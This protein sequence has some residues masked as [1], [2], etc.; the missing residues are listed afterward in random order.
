M[1]ARDREARRGMV[2]S[3]ESADYVLCGWRVRSALPLPEVAPWRGDDRPPDVTIR[4]GAAPRLVDPVWYGTG[5]VQIGRDGT[6]RLAID[7]VAWFLV[8]NGADVV[9]EPRGGIDTPEFCSWLLGTVLGMLCHQR[10]HFP[11]HASAVRIG[12]SAVAFAGRSGAGKSSLAAALLRRGHTLLADDVCALDLS[13]PE[14]PLVLPSFPR[15]KLWDDSLKALDLESDGLPRAAT[16]ARKFHFCQPGLFDGSP[17]RLRAVYL[18]Q[19]STADEEIGTVGGPEAV[20]MLAEEIYCRPIGHHLDRK[21]A[22]LA[23]ALRVAAAVPVMVLPVRRDL[24]RLDAVA[25][26]IESHAR[27]VAA[28]SIVKKGGLPGPHRRSAAAARPSVRPS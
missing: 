22:L 24:A 21:V 1:I 10:G 15:L 27:S 17:A 9:I 14:A 8:S 26:R 4:L 23:D 19:P 25:A 13:A 7:G 5:P 28:A 6:C 3:H 11:L 2:R 12:D 16:G 20:R 18:L